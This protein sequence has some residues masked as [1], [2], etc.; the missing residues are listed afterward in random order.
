MPRTCESIAPTGYPLTNG[1]AMDYGFDSHL[2]ILRGKAKP[3]L[4]QLGFLA[5]IYADVISGGEID[6]L[7]KSLSRGTLKQFV[8][9][10][11]HSTDMSWLECAWK[12]GIQFLPPLLV[13]VGTKCLRK[14]TGR[15]ETKLFEMF[16]IRETEVFLL[17]YCTMLRRSNKIEQGTWSTLKMKMSL[18]GYW[19][20]N[21]VRHAVR[22]GRHS[23]RCWCT[24]MP[25]RAGGFEIS[26]SVFSGS[27]TQ[28]DRN[29]TRTWEY[30]RL[31]LETLVNQRLN[32]LPVEIS[33]ETQLLQ[34]L[35]DDDY[36]ATKWRAFQTPQWKTC[37][38]IPIFSMHTTSTRAEELLLVYRKQRP[39][40][41]A[42]ERG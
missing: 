34:E 22:R 36:S 20:R 27:W 5:M 28:L 40:P 4:E 2:Y 37:Q 25:P 39:A 18:R 26:W 7:H 11:A 38:A 19:R 23:S 33:C 16:T 29:N 21:A 31:R 35:L 12:N 14:F 1:A 6:L 13:Y 30:G 10:R 32:F 42:F 9:D 3:D 41:L 17:S 24:T 8:Q 15:R